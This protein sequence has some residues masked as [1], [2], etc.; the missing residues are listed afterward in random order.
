MRMAAKAPPDTAN[1][2]LEE[3]ENQVRGRVST[4]T[5]RAIAFS[6][7]MMNRAFV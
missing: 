6:L 1:E 3:R 4:K 2:A 7:S 5:S